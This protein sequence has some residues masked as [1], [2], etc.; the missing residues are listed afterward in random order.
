[1][2][3][4]LT[5]TVYEV[6]KYQDPKVYHRVARG[7]WEAMGGS[8]QGIFGA[9]DKRGGELYRLFA[10]FDDDAGDFGGT[11]PPLVLLAGARKPNRTAMPNDVY[12]EVLEM[13]E[14]CRR[15][16]R[17]YRDLIVAAAGRRYI[18]PHHVRR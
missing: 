4:E 1:V 10:F 8:M 6:T 16:P 3:R 15:N 17:P 7:R 12:A 9:R 11:G 2:E 14:D 18:D 5:T 13:L